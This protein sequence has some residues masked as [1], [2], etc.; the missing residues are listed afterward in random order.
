MSCKL[1]TAHIEPCVPTFWTDPYHNT[2]MVKDPH[3]AQ[4]LKN[5]TL[6]CLR[7]ERKVRTALRAIRKVPGLN[8]RLNNWETQQIHCS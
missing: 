5:R 8:R 6:V 2:C 3:S 7:T 4:E 1:K